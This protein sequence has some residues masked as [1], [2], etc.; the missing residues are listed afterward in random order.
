M[1]F[2]TTPSIPLRRTMRQRN[3]EKIPDCPIKLDNDKGVVFMNGWQK[4]TPD[5]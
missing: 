1:S 5:K 3:S 2:D 4:D